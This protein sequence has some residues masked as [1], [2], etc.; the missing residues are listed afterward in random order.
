M[1]ILSYHCKPKKI[2]LAPLGFYLMQKVM[3]FN[4]NQRPCTL[5]YGIKMRMKFKRVVVLVRQRVY[6]T[7]EAIIQ[8]KTRQSPSW[9]Y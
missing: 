9:Y 3:L 5:L 7:I 4:D 1:N 6:C 8:K 2:V